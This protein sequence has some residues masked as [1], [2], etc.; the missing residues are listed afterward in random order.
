MNNDN[1]ESI[2][3]NLSFS[4]ITNIIIGIIVAVGGLACGVLSIISGLKLLKSRSK[5][6]Y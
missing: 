5:L 1:F 4:G 3:K 2:H 6:L